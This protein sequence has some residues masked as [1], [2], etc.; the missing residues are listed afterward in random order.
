M[1]LTP[2]RDPC[3]KRTRGSVRGVRSSLTSGPSLQ[4]WPC[5][6]YHE[7]SPNEPRFGVKRFTSWVVFAPSKT[8]VHLLRNGFTGVSRIVR[9]A[10]TW[11]L[12]FTTVQP[13]RWDM[14][15]DG[16]RDARKLIWSA[17]RPDSAAASGRV[18][19]REIEDGIVLRGPLDAP[20]APPP[21]RPEHAPGGHGGPRGRR[22]GR[23][24]HAWIRKA[25]GRTS[26]PGENV[27]GGRGPFVSG[28]DG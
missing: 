16:T 4:G 22:P 23:L 28:E 14:C 12:F 5:K 9:P 17:H 26:E 10:R 20:P 27:P 3:E 11:T 21:G 1:G 15:P 2:W 25:V 6:Y 13:S 18:T 19:V 7:P 24:A 8:S